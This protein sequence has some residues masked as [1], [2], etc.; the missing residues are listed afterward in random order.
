MSP[1]VWSRDQGR[2]ATFKVHFGNL[3]AGAIGVSALGPNLQ[4]IVPVSDQPDMDSRTVVYPS[5]DGTILVSVV[6]NCG[7]AAKFPADLFVTASQDGAVLPCA[8][9]PGGAPINRKSGQ[10]KS[11]KEASLAK[12]A[13]YSFYVQLRGQ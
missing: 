1:K 11:V 9:A 2:Q 3:G 12:G 7:Y 8:N 6:A 4:P 13:V 10:Y 5:G